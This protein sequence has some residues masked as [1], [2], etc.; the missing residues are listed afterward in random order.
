MPYCI[1]KRYKFDLIAAKNYIVKP[2]LNTSQKIDYCGN[3]QPPP[4]PPSRR[5][6]PPVLASGAVEFY[7]LYDERRG[8]FAVCARYLEIINFLL[9]LSLLLLWLLMLLWL[10]LGCVL[11]HVFGCRMTVIEREMFY[12]RAKLQ[13]IWLV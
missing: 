13:C 11:R 6:V 8:A 7:E 12:Q 3:T 1:F 4:K 5:R 10:P 2:F 9:L